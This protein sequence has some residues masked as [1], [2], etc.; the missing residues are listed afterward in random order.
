MLSVV[1]GSVTVTEDDGGTLAVAFRHP[2]TLEI[3]RTPEPGSAEQDLRDLLSEL[4]AERRRRRSVRWARVLI[5]G[6][7][8]ALL[9]PWLLDAPLDS[10]ALENRVAAEFP[11]LSPGGMLD[12]S[13]YRQTDAALRDR[14]ALRG[15]V[16]ETVGQTA[17]DRLNTSL[18]P[19]V[20]MGAGGMPFSADDFTLPC[21]QDY[22]PAAVDAGLQALQARARA[23]GKSLLVAIAPDK[24]SILADQLGIRAAALTACS[25]QVQAAT[26]RQWPQT[27]APGTAASGTPG[28][29]ASG[30]AAGPGPAGTPVVTVWQQL[31]AAERKHPGT[32]FQKGDTHW[33]TAGSLVFSRAVIARLVAQGEAPAELRGAPRAPDAFL[34]GTV[35]ADGDLYRMMGLEHT[36]TVPLWKVKRR[37]VTLTS[38]R[39]DTPSGRGMPVYRAKTVGDVPVIGG[40]TLVVH[41]S[42]F[43]RAELQ[44][45]P[46]FSSL[47]VMH[48]ADFLEAVK[49]G[50]VPHFDRIILET[51]QRGWTERAGW[52][53]PGQDVHTALDAELG[54]SP[55]STRP[56]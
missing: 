41:D 52:L 33:T 29:P 6:L 1:P 24:S 9:A 43:S 2:D 42:F 19:E 27:P 48:W 11:R 50:D 7:A 3:I 44:L 4:R 31:A 14:L 25:R 22:R 53:E 54:R 37:G 10:G 21:E 17:R 20:V 23:G 45:A 35:D 40:R 28:T 30:T 38:T 47:A 18:N 46:Y 32:V 49:A 34:V 26:E 56:R 16:A 15:R 8:L 5:G 13:D 12:G 39:V 55:E 51:V 36:E